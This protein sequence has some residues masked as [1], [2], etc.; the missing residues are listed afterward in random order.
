MN[1]SSSTP[2]RVRFAP[3]PT[4]NLHIGNF[5]TAIFNWLF[6]RHHNG[7]FLV[8]IEDTDT[9]RSK[10]EYTQGILDALTWADIN[11]DE[12]LFIQSQ[13]IEKH[14]EILNRLVDEGKAYRCYCSQQ[15]IADRAADAAFIKYDG[16]C[17][18]RTDASDTPYVIRFKLPE[19]DTISFDDIIRGTVSFERDQLDDFI[20]ARSDGNPIYN[21]VVVIDDA[22]MG[23]THV[24]RGEDHISN[25]PKQIL[26]YQ[27]CGYTLPR[28][29]HLPMILGP[30]G[31]RL[32]KR[33]GATSVHE[34][35]AMGY[36]PDAFINYLVRL[37]WSHGDQEIF[38]RDEL[39]EFFTLDAVG[40]KGSIFDQEKLNW[41]NS[42]YIK[43]ASAQK[44]YE[45][46]KQYIDPHIDTVLSHW[47]ND[48]ICKAIDLYKERVTT[49]RELLDDLILL[50]NGPKSYTGTDLAKWT[51]HQTKQQ[52]VELVNRLKSLDDFSADGCNALVKDLVKQLDIKFVALAQPIRIALLGKS[53]GPGIFEM[54]EILGKQEAIERIN[55]LQEY[56]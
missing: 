48:A 31:D 8:R 52:L 55:R 51:T 47:K 14:K 54:C 21:F 33:D 28:F 13:A 17:R 45:Y 30:S 41:V 19:F 10:Q 3:S 39:I 9:A 2:V 7:K 34:F 40:K 25:T 32:S 4:G 24:I 26:L 49:M 15:E 18:N 38:S 22:T 20:I 29:A 36:L 35:K 43:A 53:S 1:K 27:A 56:L 23:I 16:Y 6:A 42:V 37:G 46:L 50:H 44:L 12:E 5:R 11:P